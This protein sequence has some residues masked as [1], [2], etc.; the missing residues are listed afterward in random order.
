MLEAMK[1]AGFVTWILAFATPVAA[2]EF[3]GKT[4]GEFEPGIY[5]KELPYR[6]QSPRGIEAGREYPLLLFL[7]GRGE[8][9]NDNVAQLKSVPPRLAPA[10]FAAQPC[11]V[12][13]PQCPKEGW[14]MGRPLA[15]ALDLVREAVR[16]LPVDKQRVYISGLSMGGFGTWAAL[17]QEPK[18][19]A[20]AIPICGGGEPASV[21]KFDRVPIWAFHGEADDVVPV[22]KS[23]EMV[24]ALRKEKGADIR[25]TE[26]PGVKHDSWT[27]TYENPELYAW[28]FAQKR[29]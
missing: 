19:F 26:Y 27:Q 1:K 15:L 21:R 18:L 4:T 23:R 3:E 14:W 7:H 5:S 12:I 9:G 17:A 28:L 8:S 29:K 24:E 11:F 16:E 10:V 2:G 20:A 6:I 13:A 25:Y 22:A